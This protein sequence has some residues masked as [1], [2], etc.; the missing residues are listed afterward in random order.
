MEDDAPE[1]E[2]H[3]HGQQA[4]AHDRSDTGVQRQPAVDHRKRDRRRGRP[5]RDPRDDGQVLDRRDRQLRVRP[6][7]GRDQRSRL[8]VPQARQNRVS[9]VAQVQNQGGPDIL[10]AVLAQPVPRAPL[11]ARH[12]PVLPRRVPPD[13]RIPREEQSGP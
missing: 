2:S 6:Q 13:H 3:V 1:D 7:A 12:H 4:E 8:G 10:A 9:A 11:L 5:H